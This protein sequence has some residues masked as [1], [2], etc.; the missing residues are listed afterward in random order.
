MMCWATKLPERSYVTG[1][2]AVEVLV[3]VVDV[4]GCVVLAVVVDA[5]SLP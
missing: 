4:V 3:E 5:P 1:G 2:L